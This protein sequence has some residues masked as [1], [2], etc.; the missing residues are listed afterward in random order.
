MR[1]GH[2]C[3]EGMERDARGVSL[4]CTP[5]KRDI[6]R[7]WAWRNDSDTLA[8]F[9]SDTVLSGLCLQVFYVYPF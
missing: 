2:V 7:A 4:G 9:F 3:L 6:A 1:C 8:S 5:R